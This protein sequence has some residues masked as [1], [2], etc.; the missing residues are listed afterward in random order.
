MAQRQIVTTDALAR[1]LWDARWRIVAVAMCG[2]IVAAYIGL[3][4]RPLYESVALYG[5]PTDDLG[6]TSG[7]AAGLLG[8]F[9]AVSGL[10]GLP[11]GKAT[12][13]EETLAVLESRDFVIRFVRGNNLTPQLFAE[14]WSDSA[15]NWKQGQDG[16]VT[17]IGRRVQDALS[18]LSPSDPGITAR[19]AAQLGPSDDEIFK[20]FSR[21]VNLSIDRRTGFVKVSLRAPTPT[22]ARDWATKMIEVV[23]GELRERAKREA[24][25]II[26]LLAG[27]YLKDTQYDSV[28]KAAALLLEGQLKRKV[29][30]DAR[31]DFALRVL[32]PPSLAETRY[33]P[34]R[35]RMVIIGFILGALLGSCW[36]F[37]RHVRR[38][39]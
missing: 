27:S 1:I 8:Q 12:N 24:G 36:A 14:K 26:E 9:S 25:V 33:S 31:P 19:R 30:I 10:L 39:S 35:T 17:S 4:T 38:R 16:I 32:D 7:G 13:I 29:I 22:L 18:S 34:K 20:R 15:H 2:A 23:N 37:I 5:P 3:T 28:R 6:S 11:G 21:N